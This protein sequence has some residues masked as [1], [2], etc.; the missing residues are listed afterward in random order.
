MAGGETGH[1]RAISDVDAY[2]PATNTWTSLTPLPSARIAGVA[3]AL[4]N[5]FIYTGGS[6]TTGGWRA[7]P[8]P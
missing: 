8:S 2:D 3:V 1:T 6:Y 7:T 5:D 4:G